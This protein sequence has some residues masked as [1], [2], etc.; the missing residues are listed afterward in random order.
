MCRLDPRCVHPGEQHRVWGQLS[1]LTQH[2]APAQDLRPGDQ[3]QGPA[4]V[5]ISVL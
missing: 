4:Q 1:P 2:P 5:Q 3:A